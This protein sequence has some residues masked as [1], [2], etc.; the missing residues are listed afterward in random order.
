MMKSAIYEGVVSHR[1]FLPV[2]HAFRYRVF[3][4][5]LDLEELRE[6]FR[7]RWLWSA[8]RPAIAW[9]RRRDHFGDPTI[10][11]ETAVGDV[12]ESR[13]GHRP[14]G[15]I[16]LLTNLR[17]FGYCIN[18]VSFYFCFD[19]DD[20]RVESV[21]AEVHNTPWGE[22]HCYVLDWSGHAAAS[23]VR[24]FQHRKVFHVSPF[25]GMDQEYA[26]RM[27]EPHEELA[28]SIENLESGQKIFRAAL[29]LERR[30]IS[31][32]SLAGVL[33]RHPLMTGRVASAIYWQALRLWLKRVRFQAHPPSSA[34]DR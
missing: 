4:M 21:V 15:P 25:M 29:A 13:I 5:Y 6:V 17:Y 23:A 18:P 16:R 3:M 31:G 26:W 12:V 20:V 32:A 22:M 9:F 7:G 24:Q 27:T 19:Q 33:V 10:A 30:E 2:D 14:R 8:T 34:S 1:R 11:L 28:V